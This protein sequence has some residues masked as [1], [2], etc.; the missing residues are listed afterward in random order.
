MEFLELFVE[1]VRINRRISIPYSQLKRFNHRPLISMCSMNAIGEKLMKF[2]IEIQTYNSRSY[3]HS[4]LHIYFG[5]K[6]F[7]KWL[8]IYVTFT[9]FVLRS[10]ELLYGRLY[11]PTSACVIGQ[12]PVACRSL[13][14]M[15]MRMTRIDQK[16]I[17]YMI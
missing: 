15:Y 16:Y 7:A 5:I 3:I 4:I 6:L 12:E 10:S 1:I 11:V 8:N 13:L 14:Q 17:S 2:I 9:L